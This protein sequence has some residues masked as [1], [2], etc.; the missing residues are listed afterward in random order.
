MRRATYKT[1]IQR[2]ILG[3]IALHLFLFGFM[4]LLSHKTQQKDPNTLSNIEVEILNKTSPAEPDQKL[5]IVAQDEKAINNELD[6]KA[7]FLSKN[8]QRVEK[9]TVA[10]DRSDFKNI[11][12][13]RQKNLGMEKFTPQMDIQKMFERRLAA[14]RDRE[15]GLEIQAQKNHELQKIQNKPGGSQVSSTLD[16]IPELDPGLETMLSTREFVY[17]SF[18]ARIRE[19]LAQHWGPKVREKISKMYKQGRQ[20]AS[21]DDRITKLL[22]TLDKKGHFVKAQIIGDSGIRDLD[23]AAV[24][25]FRAAAP[26]PNPPQ[27][28]VDSDGTIKI[29][30]DFI[31]ES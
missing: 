23:E 17:Y 27:G 30:W 25:A 29:R 16:Y 9:Q 31:L 20:I 5:Q 6:P 15:S 13:S 19:Q 10:Q 4:S 3:S 1:R 14:E 26:F 21:T 18:Y 8:N 28:I 2:G 7:K 24:E 22:I 12:N 11:K